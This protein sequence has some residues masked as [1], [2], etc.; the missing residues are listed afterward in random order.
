MLSIGI[1]G[2]G[3]MGTRHARSYAALPGVKVVKVSSR[4]PEKAAA[5]AN[6]I[7]S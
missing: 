3:A 7:W 5:L 2:S 4:A 6:E 1:I